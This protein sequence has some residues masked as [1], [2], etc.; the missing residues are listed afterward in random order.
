MWRELPL[1][2]ATLIERGLRVHGVWTTH[3]GLDTP[4]IVHVH[5]QGDANRH[6][7]KVARHIIVGRKIYNVFPGDDRPWE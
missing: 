1:T 4:D 3:K 7:I 5:W 6:E 2:R